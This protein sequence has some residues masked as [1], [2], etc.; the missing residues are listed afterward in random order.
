MFQIAMKIVRVLCTF[1]RD[2]IKALVSRGENI[3]V[4]EEG[5]DAFPYKIIG[6]NM[7]EG[8]LFVR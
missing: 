2:G 5:Y 6:R 7:L 8:K 3:H 4:N 1:S